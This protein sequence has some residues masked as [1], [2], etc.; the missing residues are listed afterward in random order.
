[1]SNTNK[2][3][4]VLGLGAMGV[5]IAR[6]FLDQGYKVTLWNRTADKADALVARGAVLARSA[7]EALRASRMA[8]MCVYD[9]P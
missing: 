7:A 6:L 1:M 2:E 3:V 8:V 5:V 4:S 9:Y